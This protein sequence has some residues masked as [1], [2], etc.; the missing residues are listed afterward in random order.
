MLD[1]PCTLCTCERYSTRGAEQAPKCGYPGVPSN[2]LPS[3]L[4]LGVDLE[5][6]ICTST[7][8]TPVFPTMPQLKRKQ[9]CR[10]DASKEEYISHADPLRPHRSI[11]ATDRPYASTYMD[12]KLHNVPCTCSTAMFVTAQYEQAICKPAG[13]RLLNSTYCNVLL[14]GPPSRCMRQMWVRRRRRFMSIKICS[15]SGPVEPSP[16]I[17]KEHG[18]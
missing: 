3:H 6:S 4:T 18:C 16:K 7:R 2:L 17:Q 9:G 13:W 11:P 14:F 10:V 1:T 8:Q 12:A 15:R 5:P